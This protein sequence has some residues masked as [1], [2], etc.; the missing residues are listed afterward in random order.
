MRLSKISLRF[1]RPITDAISPYFSDL[2]LN[3]K[4]AG[5]K[6]SVQEFIGC[7]ILMM[8][9]IFVI[10]LP[11]LS[12]IFAYFLKNFLFG[13]LSSITACFFLLSIFFIGYINYPKILIS[14]KAKKIDDQISFAAIHL[15]TL[16]S[17]KLPLNKIFETFSKFGGYGEITKE[18]SM[19]DNDVKMFG[20]DIN[21]ALEKAVDRSPSKNLKELLWGILSTNISGGD[22][23]IYLREKSRSFM[24]DYRKKLSDFSH[25][26]GIYIEIFITSIILGSVFFIILTSIVAGISGIGQQIFLIQ[27]FL[28]FIFLPLISAV[29]IYLV[30]SSTPGEID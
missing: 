15:S 16:A 28:I 3:L 7:G 10:G 14:Q 12:V 25:Q 27:F 22:I 5:I 21:T 11:V 18:I 24:S 13:F 29:F 1:F 8:M 9:L 2:K 26:L 30:K 4:R 17:A 20:L 23:E 19:I 6:L